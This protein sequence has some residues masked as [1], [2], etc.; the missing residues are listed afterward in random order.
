MITFGEEHSLLGKQTSTSEIKASQPR[1]VTEGSAGY[2]R[3]TQEGDSV[4]LGDCA[5]EFDK[6]SKR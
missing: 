3:G 1:T 2:C 4:L 5:G 6:M